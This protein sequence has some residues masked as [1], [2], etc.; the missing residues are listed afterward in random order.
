MAPIDCF[1]ILHAFHLPLLS[2]QQADLISSFLFILWIFILKNPNPTWR[3]GEEPINIVARN[4]KYLDLFF[5]LFIYP[6]LIFPLFYF[7]F[8]FC[9]PLY[10]MLLQIEEIQKLIPVYY[11]FF[12]TTTTKSKIFLFLIWS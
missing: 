9:S 1:S 7:S 3:N 4:L 8:R 12:L 5:Y 2:E 6:I 10:F 11:R